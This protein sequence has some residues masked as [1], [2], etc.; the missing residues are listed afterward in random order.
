MIVHEKKLK[1]STILKMFYCRRRSYYLSCFGPQ[2]KFI[3][4]LEIWDPRLL[5]ERCV[6]CEETKY[7]EKNFV[8]RHRNL[9]FLTDASAPPP[10]PLRRRWATGGRSR[11]GRSSTSR[12]R[13][14]THERKG[15][16]RDYR[17]TEKE[18]VFLYFVVDGVVADCFPL[19]TTRALPAK[20]KTPAE[21]FP[22]FQVSK[23]AFTKTFEYS[24]HLHVAK[25]S[26]NLLFQ[27]RLSS[28]A[29]DV[30]QEIIPQKDLNQLYL[31]YE[32]HS[33]LCRTVSYH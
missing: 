1:Q 25:K 33:R 19:F 16:K 18:I 14:T 11:T 7:G 8:R 6:F 17:N 26:D 27:N 5:W 9:F 32:K 4:G 13:R 12:P 3:A 20:K 31:K 21:N 29:I 15:G 10:P 2:Q 30:P 23:T 28:V 24:I 22:G